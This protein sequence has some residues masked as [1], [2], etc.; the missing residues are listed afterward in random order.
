MGTGLSRNNISVGAVP[1][2]GTEALGQFKDFDSE[3]FS[4]AGSGIDLFDANGNRLDAPVRLVGALVSSVDGTATTVPGFAPFFGT[5]AAAPNAAGLV[6]LLREIAPKADGEQIKQALID[7][8]K[9]HPL[10]GTAAGKFDAQGGWGLIDGVLAASRLD[11]T[12][13]T[14]RIDVPKQSSG[15]DSITVRFS[16]PVTGVDISDF[17]LTRDGTNVNRFKGNET[18]TDTGDGKTFTI[19]NLTSATRDL[20]TYTLRLRNSGTQIKDSGGH[21]ALG[22]Y[23]SFDVTLHPPGNLTVEQPGDGKIRLTF[24]DTNGNGVIYRIERSIHSNFSDSSEKRTYVLSPG[25]TSFTD[26]GASTGTLYYYR[27]RA[28]RVDDVGKPTGKYGRHRHRDGRDWLERRSLPRS[29]P[30]RPLGRLENADRRDRLRQVVRQRLEDRC[31]QDRPGQHRDVHRRP[32]HGNVLCLHP[33]RRASIER[34]ERARPGESWR[35]DPLHRHHR[36]DQARRRLG[37]AQ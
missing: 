32:R 22:Q 31:A 11:S 1:Y 3:S 8:A 14:A 10:N 12:I 20:G 9:Q 26:S 5:S 4:S 24:K 2:T 37:P 35:Q 21:T 23:T 25:S 19:D 36:S 15:V 13:P 18:V 16:E 29:N 7:S 34:D 6:A 30:G 17:L 28:V 33:V 27:V